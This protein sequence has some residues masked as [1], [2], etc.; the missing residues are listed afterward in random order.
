MAKIMHET[1]AHP[2]ASMA[3]SLWHQNEIDRIVYVPIRRMLGQCSGRFMLV[4][5][6]ARG[7]FVASR[8]LNKSQLCSEPVKSLR[9][10]S[11]RYTFFA[12]RF[13]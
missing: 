10:R 3:E 12:Q 2:S 11:Q 8:E 1:T 5:G 4:Q 7:E 9:G 6:V 13:D